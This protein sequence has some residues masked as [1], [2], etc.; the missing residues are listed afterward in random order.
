MVTLTADSQIHLALSTLTEKA[1]IVDAGGN[2]LGYFLPK[3]HHNPA[4]AAEARKH[5]HPEVTKRRKAAGPVGRP[6]KEVIERLKA[7]DAT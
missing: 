2:V 4:L 1:E 6:T 3:L 7:M 5:F